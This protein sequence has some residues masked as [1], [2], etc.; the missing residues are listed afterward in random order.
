MEPENVPDDVD[1]EVL[2]KQ[3]EAKDPYEKRLKAISND[4]EVYVGGTGKYAKQSSWVIRL[5][6]DSTDYFNPQKPS[7]KINNGV[8]V[9]K[10]LQWPGAHTLHNNGRTL[11]IYIGNGLKYEGT[12]STANPGGYFPVFPPKVLGDPVERVEQPEPTPLT[13]EVPVQKQ[14]E[15]KEA[16]E[17]DGGAAEED[18]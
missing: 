10:S 17:G 16:A 18:Q 1:P 2:K 13:M 7:K 5:L 11:S 6:G 15:V 9:V 3:I 12:T 4:K 14:E 8:V